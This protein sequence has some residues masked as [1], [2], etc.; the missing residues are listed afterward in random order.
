VKAAPPRSAPHKMAASRRSAACA[1][2][3]P[4]AAYGGSRANRD[5]RP[6]AVGCGQGGVW[7]A[8]S[9]ESAVLGTFSTVYRPS[10]FV[11]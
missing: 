8:N 11:V 1:V 9:S 10:G 7:G 4:R 6:L 5:R 2:A 3:V